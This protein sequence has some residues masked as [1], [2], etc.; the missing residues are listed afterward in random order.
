MHA[1]HEQARKAGGNGQ[2]DPPEGGSFEHA[3]VC[4]WCAGLEHQPRNGPT[5]I[6]GGLAQIK[7]AIGTP[8]AMG[9]PGCC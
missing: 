1:K 6:Q 8:W 3:C 7:T 2:Q 5:A 4:V 9:M